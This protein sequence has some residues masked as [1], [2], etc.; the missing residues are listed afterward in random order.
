ASAHRLDRDSA[1]EMLTWSRE[2]LRRFLTAVADEPEYPL[3]RLAAQTGMRRGELLGLR[4]R[5]V[6]LDRARLCVRQ[7][8]VRAG[9]QVA[10]GP[11]KTS[12]GRRSI[13]LDLGTVAALRAHKASQREGRLR[14]GPAYQ[15][16][17]LVFSRADGHQHDPDVVSQR[18]DSATGRARVPRIRLHDLRHTH[19]TLLLQAGVP[20]KVVSER[21]GHSKTSITQD[22]YQ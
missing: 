21:L 17:D 2:E 9:A 12:A 8:L 18:F 15:D 5:D 19:A 13:A 3:W 1:P 4:W 22:V 14:W 11:P 10:V 7:Q 20:V 16:Q 6:D